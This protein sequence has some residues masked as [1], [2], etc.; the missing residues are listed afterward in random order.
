MTSS[1]YHLMKNNSASIR[2]I[3]REMKISASHSP[4]TLYDRS[5]GSYKNSSPPS[6]ALLMM[7]RG[8]FAWTRGQSR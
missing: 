8:C 1:N 4:S 2:A 7:A 6:D 5:L 3:V